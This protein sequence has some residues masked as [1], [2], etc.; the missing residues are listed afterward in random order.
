VW[1]CHELLAGATVVTIC[2]GIPPEGTPPTQFDTRA[3][4]PTAAAAVHARRAEDVA[5]A[6]RVGFTPRHLDCLDGGH[7]GGDIEAVVQ[8]A[9]ADVLPS[10]IVVGPAGLRHPDH[11]AV[12]S[13]FRQVV[14]ERDLAA[15]VYEDLPYAYVWPETL[16]PALTGLGE[17][18][19]TRLSSP[20]KR[21][22]VDEYR[23]QTTG[24]HMDAI[25]APERYHHMNGPTDL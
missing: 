12:A 14:T 8:E 9:L 23:S 16:A 20:A 18:T 1:S 19:I 13:A 17:R 11:V 6:R 22:A 10:E 3:G 15:W 21:A 24:A 5:A 2:A 25:L 4:F 7:G